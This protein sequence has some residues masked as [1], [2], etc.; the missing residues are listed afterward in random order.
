MD[1]LYFF[2]ERKR[3]KEEK[4][5]LLLQSPKRLYKDKMKS[6]EIESIIKSMP[7]NL[8]ETERAYYIYLK[9]GEILKED[10]DFFSA[11]DAEREIIYDYKIDKNNEGIC[12]SISELYIS[13]LRDKRVNVKAQMV[14]MHEYSPISHVDVILNADGKKYIVNLISDLYRIKT[15]S[16]IMN[17]GFDL[18]HMPVSQREQMDNYLYLKRIERHMGHIDVMPREEIEKMNKKFGYTYFDITEDSKLKGIYAED[19]I[20]LLKKEFENE[21][22]EEFKQYVLKGQTVDKDDVLLY[23]V[24]YIIKNIKKLV[25]FT[26]NLNYRDINHMYQ[27]VVTKVLNED[28]LGRIEWYEDFL[29]MRFRDRLSIVKVKPTKEG[30]RKGKRSVFYKKLRNEIEYTPTSVDEFTTIIADKRLAVEK[31]QINEIL[32]FYE[33]DFTDR[34]D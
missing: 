24:E 6:D 15:G 4:K 28:E 34:D 29:G 2:K 23:K 33:N 13:M 3:R 14:R 8:T 5:R 21:D 16:K 32:E 17:F 19:T 30:A 20:E 7:P 10:P 27:R 18:E 11:N 9:L 12:K 1:L 26:G 25:E 22:S 31:K